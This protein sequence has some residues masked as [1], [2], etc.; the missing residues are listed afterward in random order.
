MNDRASREGARLQQVLEEYDLPRKAVAETA[1]M[2][3]ANLSRVISGKK[4]GSLTEGVRLGRAI[5]ILQEKHRKPYAQ[6]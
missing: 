3:E 1:R 6:T 4:L 5:E 2:S